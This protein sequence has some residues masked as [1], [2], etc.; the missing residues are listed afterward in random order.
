MPKKG[1]SAAA[2]ASQKGAVK[3]TGN[4]A[5]KAI[6]KNVKGTKRS[7][8]KAAPGETPKTGH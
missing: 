5:V 7:S 1:Y 3:G 8:G 2:K 4:R 6:N